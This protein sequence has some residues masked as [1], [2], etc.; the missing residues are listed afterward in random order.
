M[1]TPGSPP[2]RLTVVPDKWV[3]PTRRPVDLSV[4][5]TDL[6]GDPDDLLKTFQKI[7]QT[8]SFATTSKLGAQDKISVDYDQSKS[9]GYGKMCNVDLGLLVIIDQES[10]NRPHPLTNIRRMRRSP[11]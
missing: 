6:L 3:R 9:T 11:L 4:G 2:T 7:P 10:G 5:P 8:T 1:G